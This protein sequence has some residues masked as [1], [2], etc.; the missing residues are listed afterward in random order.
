MAGATINTAALSEFQKSEA[1]MAWQREHDVKARVARQRVVAAL[2]DAR[3]RLSA[4]AA[5]HGK[6]VGVLEAEAKAARAALDAAER[7][8][9][10]ASE[11]KRTE[12][13]S[14][15]REVEDL[16]SQLGRTADPAIDIAEREMTARFDR[17]RGDMLSASERASGPPSAIS[18]KAEMVRVTNARAIARLRAAILHARDEFAVLRLSNPENVKGAIAKILEP[19][20]KAWSA[21]DELDPA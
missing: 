10:E 9:I 8:L 17:E 7:K 5:R 19:V 14:L 15:E 16:V 6:A 20:E 18:G 13:W 21:I 3:K 12:V 2:E 4:A 1:F 11:I